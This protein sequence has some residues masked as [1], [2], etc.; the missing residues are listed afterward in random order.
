MHFPNSP[1]PCTI[2]AGGIEQLIDRNLGDLYADYDRHTRAVLVRQARDM[3]VCT[4]FG[5]LPRF[6]REFLRPAAQMLRQ[7]Y[8]SWR[9]NGPTADE[10]GAHDGQMVS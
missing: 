5:D 2:Q 10:C 7:V 1:I 8:G 4:F 3:L 9:H 6:E